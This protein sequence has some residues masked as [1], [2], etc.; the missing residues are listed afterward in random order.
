M[1][2]THCDFCG[3]DS[4]KVKLNG[5]RF[6]SEDCKDFYQRARWE[7]KQAVGAHLAAPLARKDAAVFLPRRVVHGVIL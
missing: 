1:L 4:R 6:C 5:L 7:V 2:R 3:G